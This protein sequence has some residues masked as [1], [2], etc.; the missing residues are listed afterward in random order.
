MV[1]KKIFLKNQSEALVLLGQQDE[2]L[3]RLEHSY[4]VQ[5]FLR[6]GGN[7]GD[8]SLVIRGASGKVDRA[9]SELESLRNSDKYGGAAVPGQRAGDNA[10]FLPGQG[11]RPAGSDTIYV[12]FHGKQI[13]P[14][15]EH[16][17]RYIEAVSQYDIVI[18][19][20]P[21]GT[22]KTFL[23]VATALRALQSGRIS[24][25]VLTR[26]VVEAGEKL[27][28]LPGDLY[29]K[30]NPY[31]KPLYDAF[32]LML[33]PEKF[34]YL[35]DEETI[36]IVPLAYMRGRTIEDAFIILDEAQNTT[37]EQMKMLLTRLGSDSQLVITGDV[38]QIDLDRKKQSGL[39]T[40]EKILGK[41]SGIKFIHF[42][43]EDVVRH[44]LVKK[45]IRVYEEWEKL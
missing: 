39:V 31:L 41:V 20:G 8:F 44:D 38:T 30:I 19:I 34:R 18:G 16:Q 17:K 29:E 3:R 32:Y 11:A 15:S 6:Q 35:R 36:E 25:I 28:F 24:R 9:L 12:T 33:G 21:A 45:V 40:A 14:R 2:N 37:N 23:A 5:I 26:P 27:G 10:F 22:G 43:E 1:T 4:G 7:S 42:G 13:K